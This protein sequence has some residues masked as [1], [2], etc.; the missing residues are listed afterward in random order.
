MCGDDGQQYSRRHPQQ[1]MHANSWPDAGRR[2][3]DATLEIK[4]SPIRS[5]GLDVGRGGGTDTLSLIPAPARTD[6]HVPWGGEGGREGDITWKL[7]RGGGSMNEGNVGN[8]RQS[9]N[10]RDKG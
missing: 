7:W 2:A 8:S 9:P 6:D 3:S 5:V 10:G 4:Q 1:E